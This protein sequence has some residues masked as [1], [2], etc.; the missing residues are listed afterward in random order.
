M[1]FR[2]ERKKR[3]GLASKKHNFYNMGCLPTLLVNKFTLM[4]IFRK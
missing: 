1:T 3:M 4:N 2:G